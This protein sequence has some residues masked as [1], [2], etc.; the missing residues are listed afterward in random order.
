[1]PHKLRHTLPEPLPLSDIEIDI[2]MQ[3]CFSIKSEQKNDNV[4]TTETFLLIQ[5]NIQD[6]RGEHG[7]FPATGDFQAAGYKSQVIYTHLQN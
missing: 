7:D 5:N 1:M 4:T 3:T 2:D 6:V